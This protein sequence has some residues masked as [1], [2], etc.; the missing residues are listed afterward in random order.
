LAALAALLACGF[1]SAQPPRVLPP[2]PLPAQFSLPTPPVATFAPSGVEQAA[3][4]PKPP[5]PA[6]V[7]AAAN[8]N[9][10]EGILRLP[11]PEEV[12]KLESE[13]AWKIRQQ[14]KA[15][16]LKRGDRLEFPKPLVLA[17]GRYAGRTWPEMHCTT[18]PD[19]V[20]Y[21]KLLFEQKNFERYGWDL[22]PITPVVSAFA[23]YTDFWTV[24]Y[25]LATD[26][27]R[28]YECSAGY[29]KPGDPVP[30]MLYPLQLSASGALAETAAILTLVVIFP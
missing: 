12:F 28:C 27:F 4:Q 29:C 30:L 22:G 3:L 19:Y 17:K 8:E 23:F 14:N 6:P 11:G 25:H 1:A 18:E 15:N 24:P 26:P 20:C 2:Q 10:Y 13:E 21:Q 5:L 9:P 7:D 16:D